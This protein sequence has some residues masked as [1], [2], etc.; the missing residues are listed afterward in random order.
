MDNVWRMI[1][2]QGALIDMYLSG[3]L[4]MAEERAAA[5]AEAAARDR[6]PQKDAGAEATVAFNREQLR[7]E[8]AVNERLASAIV[9]NHSMDWQAADE[10]RETAWAHNTPVLALGK[11]G[12]GKTTV[13]KACIRNACAQGGRVLFALPTA[14]LASRTREAFREN[15]EVEVA[16][17]HAAFKLDQ[18][19][20]ESLP[21]MTLYES[22]WTRYPCWTAHSSSVF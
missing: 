19:L 21:L 6:R 15:S 8:E 22:W 9:A 5:A 20:A 14:Q 18:P 11:P 13:V 2:G 12:T 17:C 16:T 7:F 4:D 10:A 1:I 3:A